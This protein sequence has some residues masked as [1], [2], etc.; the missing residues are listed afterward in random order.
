LS[1]SN[2]SPVLEVFRPLLKLLKVQNIPNPPDMTIIE[3]ADHRN[4]IIKGMSR[5]IVILELDDLPKKTGGML[6]TSWKMGHI[7]NADGTI[8][9][10]PIEIY[11]LH[12]LINRNIC[13]GTS[14]RDRSYRK[15]T[16]VHEFMHTI[17]ALC[18]LSR[19]RTEIIR[20]TAL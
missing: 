16:V 19:A 1:R 11:T 12:I 17:A 9:P 2:N 10:N 6:I 3:L 15:I 7:K 8:D 20:A 5:C 14:H 18:A 13:N 4:F